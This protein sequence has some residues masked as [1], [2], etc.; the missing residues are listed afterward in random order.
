MATAYAFDAVGTATLGANHLTPEFLSAPH[1]ANMAGHAAVGCASAAASGGKC[2]P[3]A[4]SGA[5]GSF[6][7]PLTEGMTSSARLVTISAAGGL[8]SVAGGGK[9]GNGAITAA[10]G[11]LYNELQI[12]GDGNRKTEAEAVVENL[13]KSPTG[14]EL[15]ETLEKSS[16]VWQFWLTDDPIPFNNAGVTNG[17]AKTIIINPAVVARTTYPTCTGVFCTPTWFAR[18]LT[19]T[20]GHEFGHAYIAETTNP[21]V[22]LRQLDRAIYYENKIARELNSSAPLR[23][24]N[25]NAFKVTP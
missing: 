21:A 23:A 15:V 25:H 12:L 19:E 8:A 5:I 18:S 22:A 13:R 7:A 2:G 3:G 9:F 6:A 4:L 10:F 20:A 17:Q 24:P 16:D 14:R 11:Y 1:I